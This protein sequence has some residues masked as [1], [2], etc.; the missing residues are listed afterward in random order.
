MDRLD[1]MRVFVAVV[2]GPGFSAAARALAMP[3]PT[4]SRK[5]AELERHVGAQL[6]VRSTRRVTVTDGGQRYYEEVRRILDEIE[7]AER[8]ASGE[9]RQPKGR[10]TVTAPTL[11]GRLHVLP[12]VIDFMKAHGDVAVQLQTTNTVV[13]LLE[14]HVDL[15]IRIGSLPDSM[16][17]AFEIGTVRQIVCA[18]PDYLARHGRPS[19]PEDLAGHHCVTFPSAGT[20]AVWAFRMPSGK[21]RQFPAPSRL[22]VNSIE[23]NVQS[24]LAAVGLVQL[25]AYQ[26]ASQVA[27]GALEIV[28][29]PYELDPTPVSLVYPQGRRMPQKTRAFADFAK[30]RLRERLE[31]VAAQCSA[32]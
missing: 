3:L 20:P 2:D 6:L 29:A 13:D 9:F 27:A 24:A 25:Y 12:I 17:I 28:L 23:G 10:L 4:V 31:T 14:E 21:T 11:F 32:S 26:A 19:A 30:P 16:M 7:D 1:A 5:I 8:Q 22:T 18:H 15:G